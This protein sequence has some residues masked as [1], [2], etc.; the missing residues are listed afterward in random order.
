MRTFLI[1]ALVGLLF[2]W[3]LAQALAVGV[4][5]QIQIDDAATAA[6]QTQAAQRA[7]N[8]EAQGAT[9]YVAP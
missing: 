9:F 1:Q 7:A 4:D 8:L 2:A 6:R 5:R 3:A